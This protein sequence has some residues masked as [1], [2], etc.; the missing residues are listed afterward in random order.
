MK[1]NEINTNLDPDCIP[2]MSSEEDK[3]YETKLN[4]LYNRLSLFIENVLY[5]KT[6]RG[7]WDVGKNKKALIV[8]RK[9]SNY[10]SK[11]INCIFHDILRCKFRKR[12]F[13]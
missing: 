7:V 8:N 4:Y 1:K 13:F 12:S 9:R 5:E 11:S 2:A 10:I 3:I 6:I